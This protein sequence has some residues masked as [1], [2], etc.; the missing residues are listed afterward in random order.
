[1]AIV[2][3]LR[4]GQRPQKF[5]QSLSRL[6]PTVTLINE[7]DKTQP[8]HDFEFVEKN[9]FCEGTIPPDPDAMYGCSCLNTGKSCKLDNCECLEDAIDDVGGRSIG[10][11]YHGSGSK[12]GCLMSRFLD[13]RYAIFECNQRCNCPATCK[14]R[15]VQKG[16]QIPL[17][18][19]KTKNRGWG[20]RSPVQIRKGQFVDTYRGEV[21]TDEEATQREASVRTSSGETISHGSRVSEAS[22]VSYLFSLD[23]FKDQVPD[24]EM[25]VIDGQYKGGPTRF[26]NH[27]CDPNLRQFAVSL[28]RGHPQIYELA[29]FACKDIPPFTELTF[30]YQDLDEDDDSDDDYEENISEKERSK[31]VK[32]MKCL[33]GTQ[34]C[35]GYMW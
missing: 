9:V 8:P 34:N 24:G 14:S 1:V 31:G 18:I 7:I 21:I 19:F 2:A 25:Y 12:E 16:R 10:F 27:S 20:L 5:S 6:Q 32:A 4:I 11:P 17:E 29:F 28:F 13:T 15:V 22:K 26:I 3:K 23:K 30:D 35:R 33:C